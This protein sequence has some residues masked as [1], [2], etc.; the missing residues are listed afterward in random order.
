MIAERQIYV[1]GVALLQ[2]ASRLKFAT[3]AEYLYC[4]SLARMP[5]QRPFPG[6]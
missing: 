5:M 4:P 1:E 2:I 6:E 3:Q